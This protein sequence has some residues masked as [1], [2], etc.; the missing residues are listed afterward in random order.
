[1]PKGKKVPRRKEFQKSRVCLLPELWTNVLTYLS[2][3]VS[4]KSAAVNRQFHQF[5]HNYID[6]CHKHIE[7]TWNLWA[8]ELGRMPCTQPKTSANHECR[9]SGIIA[10]ECDVFKGII[11]NLEVVVDHCPRDCDIRCW[12]M[13]G[14]R[15][16]YTLL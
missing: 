2:P 13:D 7:A 11:H 5:A 16:G 14:V 3:I 15:H 8:N 9:S 4:V 12:Y 10:L 1:M 6:P